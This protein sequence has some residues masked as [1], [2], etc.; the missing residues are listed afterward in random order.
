[1]TQRY[2]GVLFIVIFTAVYIGLTYVI[3]EVKLSH[4]VVVWVMCGLYAGQYSTKFPKG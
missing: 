4:F 2:F 3:D 1:M